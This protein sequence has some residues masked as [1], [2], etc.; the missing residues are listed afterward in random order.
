MPLVTIVTPVYNAARWLPE[1]LEAVR[2]QTLTSWEQILVDDGSTDESVFIEQLAVAKYYR[3]R[4]LRTPHNIGPSAARN[5]ALDAARGRFIAFLDADDLWLPEKLALSIEWMTDH[6]YPFI[7]HDYRHIS[8]DGKRI[9]NLVA[10]PNELNLRR[11]HTQRG[12]GCLTVMID[13]EKIPQFRFPPIAP[14]RAEDFCLWAS[15]IKHGYIGHRL[16]LDL[17]RYRLSPKSRSANKLQGSLNAWHL[18]RKISN[19][20]LPQAA[21][22]WI[23]YAW[24]AFVLHYHARPR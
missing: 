6:E 9:G 19:L 4:L 21:W 24:N 2:A 3:V 18:Y 16:P 11:L 20:S 17:A 1:T 12:I 8:Y 7:Y 14:Y 10:G 13:K 5:L 23:Q 15:L 22:W